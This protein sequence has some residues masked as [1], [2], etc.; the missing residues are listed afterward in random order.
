M[1]AG[2][3]RDGVSGSGHAWRVRRPVPVHR[4]GLLRLLRAVGGC[5]HRCPGP[6]PAESGM[7]PVDASRLFSTFYAGN[8]VFGQQSRVPV[9]GHGG[10]V[11]PEESREGR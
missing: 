8:P 4:A 5:E 1:P 11:T 2:G 6:A 3:P 10:S 9:R 7:A